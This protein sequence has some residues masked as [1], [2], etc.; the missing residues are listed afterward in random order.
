LQGIRNI[1]I[2]DVPKPK[3]SKDEALMRV[4]AVVICGQT[5]N[6]PKLV[7]SFLAIKRNKNFLFQKYRWKTKWQIN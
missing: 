5:W 7:E 2:E 1:Q 3:I 4:K 6:T